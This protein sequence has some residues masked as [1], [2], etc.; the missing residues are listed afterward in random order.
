PTN[1]NPSI[2][3]EYNRM[4]L[5]LLAKNPADRYPS[6]ADLLADLRK[7]SNHAEIKVGGNGNDSA[8]LIT[9]NPPPVIPVPKVEKGRDAIASKQTLTLFGKRRSRWFLPTAIAVL[10][11]MAG[12]GM[13]VGRY[14][15]RTPPAVPVVQKPVNSPI[16]APPPKIDTADSKIPQK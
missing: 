14:W 13:M 5:R 4:L 7:V 3:D 6:G 16:V 2:P 12:A 8:T 11:L 10:I 9:G 1:L 15:M